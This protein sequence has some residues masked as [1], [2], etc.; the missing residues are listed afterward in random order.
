MAISESS[1]TVVAERGRIDMEWDGGER[2]M[3]NRD[4]DLLTKIDAN[5]SNFMR[6]FDDHIRDDHEQFETIKKKTDKSAW[7]IAIGIGIITALEFFKDKIF[8]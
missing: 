5:L 3:N 6:R 1:T 2:R 4:H 7:L 8:K